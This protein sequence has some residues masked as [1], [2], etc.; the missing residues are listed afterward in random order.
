MMAPELLTFERERRNSVRALHAE[1]DAAETE[2][3][4]TDITLRG[5]ADRIDLMADGTAQIIDF[6]TGSGPSLKQARILVAPQLALEG[7]LLMRGAFGELGPL[8]PDD[9][10]YVRLK[11][12]GSVD[13]E[14]VLTYRNQRIVTA[15]EL[16]DR[17][18]EKL[19]EI[20]AFFAIAENGYVSRS[21]PF[22]QSDMDG[23][24]DHLARVLEWSAGSDD[25]EGGSE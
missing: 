16:S 21:M 22:R 13:K 12:D 2:I 5:R 18:W 8:K 17:A 11:G 7:A 20:I 4:G 1:I 24:Y 15:P 25:G 23:D 9:L 19:A 6:K 10:L 3:P 14:S